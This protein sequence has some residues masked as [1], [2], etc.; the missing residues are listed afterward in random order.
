MIDVEAGKEDLFERLNTKLEELRAS[1]KYDK[2]K[3]LYM[4]RCY[5]HSDIS[6]MID[7]QDPETLPAFITDELLKID[8]VWDLQTIHLFNPNF[9]KIPK[10][11]DHANFKPFTVTLDV[12]SDKT[13][14]VFKY[15]QEFAA[16][17][18]AAISFLAYTF[19]AY[20]NDIILTLL[21]PG[22]E[23]AGKFVNEKIRTIDGVID[24]LLWQIEKWH[25]VIPHIEWLQ[26]INYF[27]ME[28]IVSEELWDES[29]ICAC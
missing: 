9:F 14:S 20:D 8:G 27:R 4:A 3:I 5:T 7:V 29:Y 28:D 2:I 25:I 16:T 18:E 23:Q 12:K 15:L 22:V 10:H 11:V 19:Y 24:S 21:A 6:L 26:Y 13:D 17:E 1:K